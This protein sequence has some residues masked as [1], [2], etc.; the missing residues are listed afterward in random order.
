M[1]TRINFFAFAF[2]ALILLWLSG[3]TT[4]DGATGTGRTPLLP[5]SSQQLEQM[6]A[7]SPAVAPANRQAQGR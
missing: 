3:C 4:E 7:Q 6:P 5:G 2:L 1:E